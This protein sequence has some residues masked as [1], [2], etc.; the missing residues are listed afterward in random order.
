MIV[1]DFWDPI[2]RL[3]SIISES[4]HAAAKSRTKYWATAHW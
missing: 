4:D 2:R 3:G 1:Q